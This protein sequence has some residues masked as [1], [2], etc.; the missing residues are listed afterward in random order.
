MNKISQLPMCF[1]LCPLVCFLFFFQTPSL[2]G[3]YS[4]TYYFDM[5]DIEK[6]TNGSDVLLF[7]NTWQKTGNPGTPVLPALTSK[8]FIPAGEEVLSVTVEYDQPVPVK[9]FYTIQFATTPVPLSYQGIFPVDV[10]DQTIYQ[11]DAAYP[12]APYLLKGSQMMSGARIVITDLF[13]AVYSPSGGAVSYFPQMSVTVTTKES[14]QT[15][16]T[17]QYRNAV[18]DNRRISNFVD[19]KEDFI[20]STLSMVKAI[21]VDTVNEQYQYLVITTE[22]MRTA[23]QVLTDHRLTPAG[24]G[25]TTHIEAIEDIEANYTGVDLAEKM[26]NFIIDAYHDH[27]TQYVVLGGDCD[28]EAPVIPTR[29]AYATVSSYVDSNI[30]ADLYFGCLD[31]TWN[32][33]GDTLWGEMNDGVDGG[34]IDWISE[35]YVGRIAADDSTEAANHINK[36]IAFEIS[37]NNPFKTLLVGEEL[38]SNPTWGGDR[39]DWVYAYMNNAPKTKIYDKYWAGNLWPVSEIIGAVN[40]NDY[41]WINHL[42]HSDLTTFMRLYNSSI[43]FFNNNKY[44]LVYTQGCYPA[45]MDSRLSDGTYFSSDSISEVI[46]NGYGDRGAFAFIG[47]S[48]YGWYYQSDITGGSNRLH[49][50]F[51]EA[52]LVDGHATIGVANQLS[53]QD[54]DFSQGIYRW[55]G[56]SVNLLGDPATPL[57]TQCDATQTSVSIKSPE[58]GFY[59][60]IADTVVVKAAI[61]NG[62]DETVVETGVTVIASFDNGDNGDNGDN[63]L[64]LFDDGVHDDGDANDGLYGGYWQPASTQHD[65]TITVTASKDGFTSGSNLVKGTLSEFEW[66]DISQDG[67]LLMEEGDTQVTFPADIGF[68]FNFH[69]QDYTSL[70][71]HP[72][73]VLSFTSAEGISYNNMPIPD[74]GDANGMIAVFWDELTFNSDFSSK[75][76]YQTIGEAPNRKFIVT[77]DNVSHSPLEAMLTAT[78]TFQV[79]LHEG[80]NEIKFQ[81]ADVIFVYGLYDRGNSA[82][83]GIESQ[84]GITG[85]QYSYNEPKLRNGLTLQFQCVL[86]L[87]TE[88]DVSFLTPILNLLL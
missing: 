64:T 63:D 85:Q 50:E 78:V 55:I 44:F 39:L 58:N 53:K 6:L 66:I 69:G 87:E 5:P 47:N 79:I 35:V 81:Y 84:D 46:T 73:G 31:G 28:G 12:P 3:E 38:D 41:H 30:P 49:K 7:D 18:A 19:N 15:G 23:F 72:R 20:L 29:G 8:I 77:W 51:A 4:H 76:L 22:A 24:G 57:Q 40:S 67:I 56:F 21:S 26:R 60:D 80:S 33:D 45:S 74:T 61:A 17:V 70:Y 71:V 14:F 59:A 65:S 88:P 82:T 10:P 36:I 16:K 13:P 43:S 37:T 68:S 54:L 1:F 52:I 62:C 27:G 42:G 48:R 25:Y 34:D 83:V 75:L 9:G 32:N 2:A 86:P 11:A